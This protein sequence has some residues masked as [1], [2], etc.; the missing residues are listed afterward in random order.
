MGVGLGGQVFFDG[1]LEGRSAIA[2]LV[3]AVDCSKRNPC[4]LIKLPALGH[5]LVS[6]STPAFP[7]ATT[8]PSTPQPRSL[9]H[10]IKADTFH[11][12][13]R[14]H[15]KDSARVVRLAEPARAQR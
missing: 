11:H 9:V 1:L 12:D 7:Q 8:T 2:C 4:A 10:L 15:R 3:S 5:V 6:Q 13:L 14:T